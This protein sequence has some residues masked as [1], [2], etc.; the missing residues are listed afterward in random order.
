MPKK[1]RVLQV[2]RRAR[3]LAVQLLYS[4]EIRPEQDLDECL[5]VF[6]K[7][8]Y[9]SDTGVDGDVKDYMVFLAGEVW[10]ARHTIDDIMRRIVT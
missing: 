1:K 7:W 3:E 9:A 5:E 2:R 4:L 8:G 6:I 10:R